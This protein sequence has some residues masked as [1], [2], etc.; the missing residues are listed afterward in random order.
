M[1]FD[2]LEV[3]LKHRMGKNFRSVRTRLGMSQQGM[4]SLLDLSL[5]QYRRYENG[6]DLPK[7]NNSMRWSLET[8]IPTQWLFYQTCYSDLFDIEIRNEWIPLLFFINN[9]EP[10]TLKAF[11]TVLYNLSSEKVPHALIPYDRD[12]LMNCRQLIGEEY[13]KIISERL[14]AFRKKMKM[15]QEDLAEKVNISILTYRG[16]ETPEKAV[17]FSINMAMRF[18]R[19]TNVNPIEMTKGSWVYLY[20]KQQ[21][22]NLEILV[23][24]FRQLNADQLV[25][26]TDWVHQLEK[27][28]LSN[29]F[30]IN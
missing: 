11:Q 27:I 5:S 17:Q 28:Q 21:R 22:H 6:D 26:I 7:L 30:K 14:K 12:K 13:V 3:D 20:R 19:V 18:W 29:R 4:A 10:Y 23:P 15:T 24:I 25:L 2:K 9:A 1:E 8:G 16:Y